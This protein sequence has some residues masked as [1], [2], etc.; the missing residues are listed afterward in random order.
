MKLKLLLFAA[1]SLAIA[2]SAP[3]FAAGTSSPPLDA[4]SA[5]APLTMATTYAEATVATDQVKPMVIATVKGETRFDTIANVISDGPVALRGGKNLANSSAQ[6][7]GESGSYSVRPT[8][9]AGPGSSTAAPAIG[10]GPV[11]LAKLTKPERSAA[12]SIV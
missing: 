3:T 4:K 7:S 11:D 12:T 10:Y 5:A 1:T 2:A 6:H 8:L 9:A